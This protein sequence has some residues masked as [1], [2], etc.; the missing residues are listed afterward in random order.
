MCFT[1]PLALITD[2][3][4][5]PAKPAWHGMAWLLMAPLMTCTRAQIPYLLCRSLD[6]F[7]VRAKL[8]EG[9]ISSVWRAVDRRCVWSSDW[10]QVSGGAQ[11]SALHNVNQ[12]C[13]WV[14]CLLTLPPL[15]ALLHAQVWHYS[16]PQGIQESSPVRDGE[17]P[18]RCPGAVL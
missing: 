18:G 2:G 15:T 5:L 17:A 1:V 7:D 10:T 8:Y 6:A 16:C 9:G 14:A 13:R 11:Q 4:N 3:M 12:G